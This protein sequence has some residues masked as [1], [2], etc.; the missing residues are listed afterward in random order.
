MMLI[1]FEGPDIIQKQWKTQ[2][3][4][5]SIA[6]KPFFLFQLLFLPFTKIVKIF[7]FQI[8]VY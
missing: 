5:R 3:Y 2:K 4:I 7:N 6:M 8:L 1:E